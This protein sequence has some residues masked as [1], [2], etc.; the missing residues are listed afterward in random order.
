MGMVQAIILTAIIYALI[1]YVIYMGNK[2]FKEG[3]DAYGNE[4]K[5]EAAEVF[6]KIKG[7]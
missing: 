6:R 7:E 5:E 1:K 2:A 4:I 3:Y